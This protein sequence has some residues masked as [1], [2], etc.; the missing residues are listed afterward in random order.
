MSR[1]TMSH[2]KMNYFRQSLNLLFIAETKRGIIAA[3]KYFCTRIWQ[4]L[5]YKLLDSHLLKVDLRF[6]KV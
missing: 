2:R 3:T 6:Q 5:L 1:V 4:F